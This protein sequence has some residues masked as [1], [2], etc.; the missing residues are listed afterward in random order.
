[1]G[2]GSSKPVTYDGPPKPVTIP[3]ICYL[4]YTTAK[5]ALTL[6]IC[7][8]N[9]EPLCLITLPKGWFGG[10]FVHSGM[11]K[12]DA[13]LTKAELVG[14]LGVS[15][16]IT[17]Y[18]AISD[19][20]L[21]TEELR[22]HGNG[23]LGAYAF[24]ILIEAEKLPEKFEW[25]GSKGEEVKNLGETSPGFKLVRIGRDDEVVAVW[26]SPKL[27]KSIYKAA[28]FQF[29][30]SGAT[31]ELGEAW[32]KMAVTSFLTMYSKTMQGASVAT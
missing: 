4:Y 23:W 16:K 18:P 28:K 9:A 22:Y 10:M 2:S 21:I 32:A 19:G 7:D 8:E 25:R 1:M 12:E 13:P 24:A 5:W 26:A 3:N 14:K 11:S 15:S 27:S 30:G 20:N 29:L 6:H 31:G 17:I